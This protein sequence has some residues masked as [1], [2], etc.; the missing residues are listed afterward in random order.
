MLRSKILERSTGMSSIG[1]YWNIFRVPL[2]K[3]FSSQILDLFAIFLKFLSTCLHFETGFTTCMKI[4]LVKETWTFT[5][6]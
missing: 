6:S 2:A 4:F 3:F 1:Q 5:G